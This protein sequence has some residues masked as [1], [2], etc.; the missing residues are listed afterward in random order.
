M[1]VNLK[2]SH[3]GLILVTVPLVFEFIFVLV[4]SGLLY[5]AE[6]E[7]KNEILSNKI[8][9]SAGGLAKAVFWGGMAAVTYGTTG[10]QYFRNVYLREKAPIDSIMIE[11]ERLLIEAN[12]KEQIKR[13]GKVKRAMKEGVGLLDR[14]VA[15]SDRK[16]AGEESTFMAGPVEF[17]R[18][19]RIIE[20]LQ[21]E[22]DFIRINESD[23]AKTYTKASTDSRALVRTW[24]M[25]FIGLNVG[26]A[27]YLAQFFTSSVTRRLQSVME[28]TRRVPKGEELTP[29]ISGTDEIAE[30][31][32]VFHDMVDE[33]YR[34]E[35]MKQFLLSMVSHD[36][37]SPLTSVQGLL[38][39]LSSG[40]LG[41]LTPKAV[42]RINAA[43]TELTRLIK[44][45]N[46][47]LDVERLATGKLRMTLEAVDGKEIVDAAYV[48]MQTFAEQ[49]DVKL[50]VEGYSVMICGDR[51]RLIQVM[52]NLISN[53]VKYS[54]RGA[55]VVLSVG[56]E[57]DE[58]LFQ[59][60]DNG[61][62][63]PVEFRL[64]IFEKFQQ[65]EESDAK[66]KGGKGLGL[67]ICKSI[68]DGHSGEI[69]LESK[70]GV[71][72]TFWFRIPLAITSDTDKSL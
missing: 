70:F 30:L 62:G 25:G 16:L 28:N 66:E 41:E 23:I 24:L 65:V 38:T 26:L 5:Q 17:T 49:H 39:L 40:A 12:K 4:L 22:L 2:I 50:E 53:A 1:R 68:V 8:M 27:I 35:R 56:K 45:T 64:K 13:L 61:R 31:D 59:V 19:K 71:G 52:V 47:L 11:L 48:S 6:A 42:S 10:S 36:L 32:Q 21:K 9:Y 57:R 55:S 63:V 58:A 51:E 14:V 69:G 46:D 18:T 43:E 15:S 37:R 3:K 29:P 34:A 54:P 72:S 67:A 60:I 44:M 20:E 7:L 33:L